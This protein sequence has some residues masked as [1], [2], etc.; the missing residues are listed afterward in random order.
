MNILNTA[1]LDID[2]KN[3]SKLKGILRGADIF[4][5][6]ELWTN[7]DSYYG[8]FECH[9]KAE[10]LNVLV[11]ILK[12]LEIVNDN[13]SKSILKSKPNCFNFGGVI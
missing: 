7:P 13:E 10:Q 2:W 4:Y 11:E 9:P 3:E 8:Y 5:S 12:S 6:S 1:N